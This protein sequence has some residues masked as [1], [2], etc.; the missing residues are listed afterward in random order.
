MRALFLNQCPYDTSFGSHKQDTNIDYYPP[1]IVPTVPKTINCQQW[2]VE[3]TMRGFHYGHMVSKHGSLFQHKLIIY[4]LK[5]AACQ[6][7]IGWDPLHSHVETTSKTNE[8]EIKSP[9]RYAQVQ[10]LETTEPH[11]SLPRIHNKRCLVV[12][13]CHTWIR[14][15]NKNAK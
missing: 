14:N 11:A 5:F 1:T 12:G 4:L 13:L 15:I 3:Q 2:D 8:E 10:W 9:L 6:S 7:C